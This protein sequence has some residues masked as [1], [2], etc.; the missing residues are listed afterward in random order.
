MLPY[1]ARYVRS[2][3]WLW[4]MEGDSFKMDGYS[5]K[6][7]SLLSMAFRDRLQMYAKEKSKNQRARCQV[8]NRGTVFAES[9][10]FDDNGRKFSKPGWAEKSKNSRSAR[11][12]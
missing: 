1:L 12:E 5:K 6:E 10:F 4:D 3:F 11:V 2:F 7:G 9:Y 8:S